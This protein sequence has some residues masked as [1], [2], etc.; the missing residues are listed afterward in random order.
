MVFYSVSRI[1]A[2]QQDVKKKSLLCFGCCLFELT[3]KELN[4]MK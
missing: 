2:L 1:V 3:W 4:I